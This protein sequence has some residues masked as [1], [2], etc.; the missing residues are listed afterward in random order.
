MALNHR[1][2]F[3]AALVCSAISAIAAD[4]N[5]R[6]VIQPERG[7]SRTAATILDLKANGSSLSGT[8]SQAFEGEPT[9]VISKG[10]I[11][12]DSISFQVEREV[13]GVTYVTS[14]NGKVEADTLRLEMVS[15]REI[16]MTFHR[17][18]PD[19]KDK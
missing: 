6:W 10:K 13:N 2:R 12:G 11:E 16:R 14:Y 18:T 15:G 1:M 3:L 17:C 4:A 19:C 7:Q 8:I 5:G 9:R